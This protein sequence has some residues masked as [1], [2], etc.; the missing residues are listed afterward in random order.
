MK[1]AIL[2]LY[3]THREKVLYLIV[4]AWNTAFQ[5]GVFVVC[6]YF[7]S[8]H[9]HPVPILCIAYVIASVNGFLGFRYIVFGPTGHPLL[10]YA[11]YQL[12]YVPLL[13][14]NFVGLPLLLA[15][16]DLNA[17]VIQALFGLFAIVVGYLGSKH[18]AF[19]RR[20]CGAEDRETD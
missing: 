2:Q 3:R 16:T 12:V 4:G 18:F 20:G 15:K 1:R 13:V 8:P 11:R 17:Y 19:R 10:E 9:L 7:L 6:W 14:I 5:Y